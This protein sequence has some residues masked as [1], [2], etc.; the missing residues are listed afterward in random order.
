MPTH[1]VPSDALLAYA[2]GTSAPGEELLVAC[3]LTTCPS[4]R[5]AVQHAEAWCAERAFGAPTD[6]PAE[7]PRSLW[8]RLEEPEPAPAAPPS[9]PDRVV[10]APLARWIGGFGGLGWR[11]VAPGLRALR[12]PLPG[13]DQT[14]FLLDL[15]PGRTLPAH[16]HTGPERVLVLRGGFAVDG[17][18]FV[19]GDVS[20]REDDHGVVTVD[21]DAPCTSLFVTDGP[22]R[23]GLGPLDTWM[24]RWLVR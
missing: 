3:H 21:D 5:S 7:V 20:W 24:N 1:H 6:P 2:A 13:I 16:G 22:L 17:D 15:E 10:P 23:F 8:E 14:V 12:V 19:A 11:R 9:A 18:A 4:C